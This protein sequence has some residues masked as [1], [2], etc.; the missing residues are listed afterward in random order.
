MS[1]NKAKLKS[2]TR[3]SGEMLFGG[4]QIEFI[5]LSQENVSEYKGVSVLDVVI[6]CFPDDTSRGK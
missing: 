5:F 1:L 3:M 6:E 2:P 4:S